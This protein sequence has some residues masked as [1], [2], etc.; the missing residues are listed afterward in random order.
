MRDRLDELGGAE[1]VVVTCTRPR[2]LPGFR[3]RF[4]APL[5]V[6]ADED[7]RA[8]RAY[9]L[10]TADHAGDFVIDGSGRVVYAFVVEG[11][12]RPPV[13][14]LVAAVREAARS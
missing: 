14:D 2:N 11:S 9:G 4:V 1:V 5:T 12:Q 7:R 6:V 8:Y 13:D 10:E 3:G